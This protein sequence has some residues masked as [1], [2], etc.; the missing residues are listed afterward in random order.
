MFKTRR[1]LQIAAVATLAVGQIPDLIVK[2]LVILVAV[3]IDVRS[4][5]AWT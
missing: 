5:R 3:Y 2:G 1:V 4:K